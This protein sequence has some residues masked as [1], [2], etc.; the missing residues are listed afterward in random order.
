[1]MIPNIGLMTHV[2]IHASE[3]GTMRLIAATNS[4]IAPIHLA[5]K[6]HIRFILLL[7]N[8]LLFM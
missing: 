7:R 3:E 1:M 8:H 2:P 4:T 5:I 6:S